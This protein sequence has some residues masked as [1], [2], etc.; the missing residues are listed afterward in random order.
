MGW[1]STA[2]WK[3]RRALQLQEEPL[4][5]FCQQIGITTPATVAD[6][7]TPHRGDYDLFFY[8]DLQSLCDTCHSSAKQEMERSGRIR[9]HDK[10]GNPLKPLPHW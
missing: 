2:R 5:R 4:C 1:Y 10:D 3:K 6:H 8:G 7:I 9:G